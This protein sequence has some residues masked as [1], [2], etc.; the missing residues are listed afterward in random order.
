MSVG[1]RT[2]ARTH[3]FALGPKSK[4]EGADVGDTEDNCH[5]G[6]RIL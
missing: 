1:R 4:S 6:N 3:D 2:H 5:D